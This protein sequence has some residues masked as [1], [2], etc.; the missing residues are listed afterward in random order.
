M[1]RSQE[2]IRMTGLMP[3]ET[4]GNVMSRLNQKPLGLAGLY[5]IARG[6][7]GHQARRS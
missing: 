4:R 7:G 6:S 1:S 3:A 5:V 2:P